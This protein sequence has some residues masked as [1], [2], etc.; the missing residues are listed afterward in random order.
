MRY[1]LIG[2]DRTFRKPIKNESVDLYV[3][4][5][6][7]LYFADLDNIEGRQAKVIKLTKKQ[8]VEFNQLYNSS[9]TVP[10]HID[11]Y[12]TV[13]TSETK[14][15]KVNGPC[16]KQPLVIINRIAN[17]GYQC[18]DVT[19]RVINLR[20]I[21]ILRYAQ[22]IGIAN[23]R[24]YKQGEDIRVSTLEWQISTISIEEIKNNPYSNK[25]SQSEKLRNY[26]I[27]SKL[28]GRDYF[29]I[30][31]E[32]NTL[33][34]TTDQC[35]EINHDRLVLPPVKYIGP[36]AL[37]LITA[38]EVII[39]S[40]VRGIG[41]KAFSCSVI[42][43]IRIPDTVEYIANEAFGFMGSVRTLY[44][45]K[46][47]K[48]IERLV[49]RVDNE[50]L[51]EISV[52]PENPYYT[53]IDGILYNKEVTE[54][55]HFP[56]KNPIKEYIMPNTVKRLKTLRD[57]QTSILNNNLEFIRL[58]DNLMEFGTQ[59]INFFK[60]NLR[61][62]DLG[63]GIRKIRCGAVMLIWGL[64]IKAYTLDEIETEAFRDCNVT[65]Y[66][67]KPNLD[68]I[69]NHDAIENT[70]PQ[71]NNRLVIKSLDEKVLWDNQ[72]IL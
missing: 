8:L 5:Y 42:T 62:L 30:D 52:S 23:A 31:D 53:S 28:I 1:I 49:Q 17:I 7:K 34:G 68:I 11:R 3:E 15:F 21:D 56:M 2:L 59:D 9:L 44:L 20:S 67:E 47:V 45:G 70:I 51:V 4:R 57:I 14:L 29:I 10:K 48:D 37:S 39:P 22:N 41:S 6:D 12:G 13:E 16:G 32:T 38:K 54:L 71:T 27:K 66:I 43:D 46:N 72:R 24:V 19:G 65:I 55:I 58:S 60:S 50:E 25:K 36:R 63:K 61:Y 64:K 35:K 18:L 40:T 33:L 69:I 26:K